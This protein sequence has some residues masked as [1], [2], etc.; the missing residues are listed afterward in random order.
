LSKEIFKKD[1]DIEQLQ[2]DVSI[3][4]MWS[5]PLIWSTFWPNGR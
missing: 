3:S 5:S 2:E 4:R 1:Q